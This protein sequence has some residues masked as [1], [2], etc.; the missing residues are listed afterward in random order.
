M[1]GIKRPVF[2]SIDIGSNT[3]RMLLA[4]PSN[5]I[6]GLFYN[7]TFREVTRLAR[8]LGE[9]D[10]LDSEAVRTTGGVL[11]S[12]VGTARRSGADWIVA[13]GTG[14]LR[15]AVDGRRFAE[16]VAGETGLKL[17][18]IDQQTEA[19]LTLLGVGSTFGNEKDLCAI[20]IGGRSTEVIVRRGKGPTEIF[21]L[22]LGAVSLS[23]NFITADPP[24]AEDIIKIEKHIKQVFEGSFLPERIPVEM[25]ITGTGGT[26]TTLAAVDQKMTVYERKKINRYK[27]SPGRIEEIYRNLISLSHKERSSVTG[28]EPGRADIIISGTAIVGAFLERYRR[29]E[30]FVSDS[31]ILEGCI[32]AVLGGE[33]GL[34]KTPL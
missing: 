6:S 3:V 15:D 8:G 14:A 13:V 22:N 29:E 11:S 4:G 26:F 24:D 34:I 7:Q 19:R 10:E 17:N 2:A 20:D 1:T 33:P 12:Y 31:G 27:L 32:L 23:E 21:G 25:I 9:K 30:I 5:D 28:M 18:I 16:E